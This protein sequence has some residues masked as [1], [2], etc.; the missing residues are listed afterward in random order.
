[1][2]K[3]QMNLVLN[4]WNSVI[5]VLISLNFFFVHEGHRGQ[6]EKSKS[7]QAEKATSQWQS[8]LSFILAFSTGCIFL[9]SG[10]LTYLSIDFNLKPVLLFTTLWNISCLFFWTTQEFFDNILHFRD[11]MGTL[12]GCFVDVLGDV[13]GTT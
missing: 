6:K 12:L 1:M 5:F 10:L 3:G 13:V 2:S 7:L 11:A 8:R 4:A 9:R